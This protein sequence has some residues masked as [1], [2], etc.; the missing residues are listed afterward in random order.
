MKTMNFARWAVVFTSVAALSAKAALLGIAPPS[1]SPYYADV[2][3]QNLLMTYSFSSGTGTFSASNAVA[4]SF[5]T[6]MS[7]T[8][9]S[10]SPGTGGADN[11]AGFTG[12]YDLVAKVQKAA[13]GQWQ[14]MSGSTLTI[15]G[16]LPGVT[17]NNSDVLLT[18]NL[19][20]GPNT[21]GYVDQ[22]TGTSSTEFDFLFQVTGGASSIV[23]DFF[24][25]RG[26]IVIN[27]GTYFPTG[28]AGTNSL[29]S[30]FSNLGA[31]A[32]G[33]ANSFVPEPIGVSWLS[34][35]LAIAC[36]GGMTMGLARRLGVKT[37]G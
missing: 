27:S 3:V 24:D 23:A 36:I 22:H 15:E 8:A 33:N 17:A 21:F 14:V 9:S 28:Y 25:G 11:I 18:A 32:G 37:P 26:G 29:T 2:G 6:G 7:Y 4:G 1:G 30:S 13:H 20:T 19:I 5:G 34:S 10:K 31:T 12:W 16:H 35:A